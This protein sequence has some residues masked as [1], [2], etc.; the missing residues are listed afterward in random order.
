ME[1]SSV[2]E[3]DKSELMGTFKKNAVWKVICGGW[4]YAIICEKAGQVVLMYTENGL[5]YSKIGRKH[6]LCYCEMVNQINETVLIL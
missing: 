5:S 4:G 6:V 1:G 3:T 2:T